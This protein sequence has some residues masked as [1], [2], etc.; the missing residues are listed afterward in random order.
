M[1]A[2]TARTARIWPAGSGSEPSTMCSS[3]SAEADSSRVEANASTRSCGRCRTKPTVSVRVKTRPSCG[4]GPP[5][6]RV[7]GGEQRVLDQHP[8]AGEPVEQAGLAGVGVADDG[9]RRH[10]VPPPLRPLGL[11]GAVHLAQRGPQLGDPAVDPAPVGLEL[12]LAGTAAADAHAAAGPPAGLP[13][14]VAAPAAQPLLEVLQLGQLDLRL[15][16]R[17]LRACWAKMS[18][19]SAVRSITLTLTWSS[20]LRSWAGLSS[21]SQITVSAPVAITTSRSSATLPRPM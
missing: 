17:A 18:R 19:I 11:P 21:P 2:S 4:L 14:E 12:G 8:G 16:L 9:H 7:E 3:R 13:G 10:L 15:A 20:R 1:S 5:G 6:G